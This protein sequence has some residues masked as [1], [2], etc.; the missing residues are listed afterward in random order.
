MDD[1]IE[2]TK[3]ALNSGLREIIADYQIAE[4]RGDAKLSKKLMKCI[5]DIIAAKDLDRQTVF[6]CSRGET[7]PIR[8][9]QD[10]IS[11]DD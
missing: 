4:F 8:I 2:R 11:C 3:K 10:D 5:E 6:D 1:K 7:V 9:P